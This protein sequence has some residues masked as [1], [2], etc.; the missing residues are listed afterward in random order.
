M[1]MRMGGGKRRSTTILE[2]LNRARGTAY[3]TSEESEIYAE[4]LAYARAIANAWAQNQR[5]ANHWQW[6]RLTKSGIERWER[7]MQLSPAPTDS[8]ATRRRRIG[9]IF[10]RIGQLINRA[11]LEDIL[12]EELGEVFVAIE[13]IDVSL[14]NIHVPDGTYPFGTVAEGFPWYST[15][16]HVLI[17]TQRPSGYSYGDFWAA[18]QRIMPLLDDMLPAWCTFD[19]YLPPVNYA[20]INVVGGPS[21]G[22]FYLDD[23]KN[24]DFAVFDE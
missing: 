14:A 3:D 21:A 13:Y 8:D 2:S 24:L 15:A 20:P 10:E 18:V 7:I 19:W 17:R 23:E 5:L 1:P 6:S 9:R 16:L 12:R 22:G 11:K 4:H